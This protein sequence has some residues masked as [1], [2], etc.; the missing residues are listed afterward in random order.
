MQPVAY[1][2]NTQSKIIKNIL[3]AKLIASKKLEGKE[4]EIGW[5]FAPIE[6]ET[7]KHI[8]NKKRKP[9][10]VLYELIA[11]SFEDDGHIEVGL[12][13]EDHPIIWKH[14]FKLFKIIEIIEE[15]YDT[16][17]FHPA[18][19]LPIFKKR[20]VPESF[21]RYLG[22]T[23]DV[24]LFLCGVKRENEKK[25][26][27][28]ATEEDTNEMER[29][30]NQ[31]LHKWRVVDSILMSL[32]KDLAFKFETEDHTKKFEFVYLASYKSVHVYYEDRVDDRHYQE[33]IP[34]QN[35]TPQ[36]LRTLEIPFWLIKTKH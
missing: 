6:E 28:N 15:L 31:E 19:M 34:I 4:V 29:I 35:F 13:Y 21:I 23:G 32:Y 16:Y 22:R 2:L 10:T 24:N 36:E 25:F 33:V 1:Y 11:I 3:L 20:N 9:K 30:M 17:R 12:K 8:V 27:Y 26:F 18:K 7:R 14:N 5:A